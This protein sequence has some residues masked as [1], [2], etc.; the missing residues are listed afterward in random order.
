MFKAISIFTALGVALSTFAVTT[1][2]AK[3]GGNGVAAGIAGF[4]V[5]AFVGSQLSKNRSGTR[6]NYQGKRRTGSK[7]VQSNAQR[8]YWKTIQAALN[9]AGYNAGS[10]DGAPGRKTRSAIKSFQQSIPANPDG[11]L[12]AEQTKILFARSNPEPVYAAPP[13]A[14]QQPAQAFPNITLPTDGAIAG[15][16]QP[17]TGTPALA[18]PAPQTAQEAPTVLTPDPAPS[19]P[20]ATPPAGS[21]AVA[22]VTSP[23]V[24]PAISFPA[25]QTSQQAPTV[26]MPV[27]APGFPVVSE[28]ADPTIVARTPEVAV[29]NISFPEVNEATPKPTAVTI[30]TAP[31]QVE[32]PVEVGTVAPAA[33]EAPQIQIDEN[34]QPFISINGQKFLLQAASPTQ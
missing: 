29:P 6:R 23:T 28:P 16:V 1:A 18:F 22:T 30:A 10:V 12:T 25:V 32:Q 14:Y 26:T 11:K 3:A 31:T 9:D 15:A 17:V 7:G 21:S 5:G 27:A 34:G 4:A 2:P 20:V 19:F 24:S 8:E 13:T 33:V